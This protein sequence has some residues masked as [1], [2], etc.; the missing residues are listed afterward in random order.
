M[1]EIVDL[2][3]TRIGGV[4]WHCSEPDGGPDVGISVYLGK[5][6]RLWAG[7]VTNELFAQQGGAFDSDGGW[8]LI[9]YRGQD[10][11]LLAKFADDMAAR[12]FMDWMA[13]W[14]KLAAPPFAL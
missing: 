14:A 11:Q 10:T 2:E 4:T 9:R 6:H 13:A 7:E 5:D 3:D 1:T 8:F 12:D